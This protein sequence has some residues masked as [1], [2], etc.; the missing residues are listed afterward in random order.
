M[1]RDKKITVYTAENWDVGGKHHFE[2]GE[3]SGRLRIPAGGVLWGLVPFGEGKEPL[4]KSYE[5][6]QINSNEQKAG[7]QQRNLRFTAAFLQCVSF[8]LVFLQQ[9]D[10]VRYKS[11]FLKVACRFS[12]HLPFYLTRCLYIC[13]HPK[14]RRKA[15]LLP[16]KEKTSILPSQHT[17]PASKEKK[18]AWLKKDRHNKS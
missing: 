2:D 17:K 13:T 12:D 9:L 3:R 14:T 8:L 5:H 4:S 11:V 6:F 7:E 15:W 18:L 10:R 16:T 1:I